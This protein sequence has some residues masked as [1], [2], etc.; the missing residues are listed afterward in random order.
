MQTVVRSHILP[1]PGFR[2][3]EAGTFLAQLDE[4]LRL[5]KEA[6]RELTPEDLMWQPA[7]GMN[8]IGML[9]AHMAIVEVFWTKFVLGGDPSAPVEDVLGI[10]ADGDG[11]P[12]PEGG[13]AFPPLNGKDLAFYHD[14]LDRSREFLK[15]T[16][17]ERSPED[18]EREIQRER[19]DGSVRSFNVRWYYYHLLEHFSGHRGQIQL[20]VHMR[21]ATRE[22]TAR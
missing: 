5:V 19:P 9:L 13:P 14:L 6:T 1:L 15:R 18:M 20:L 17:R 22:R 12:V 10:D 7:P 21:R 4:Q 16:A 11:L 8:T 2:S 3:P